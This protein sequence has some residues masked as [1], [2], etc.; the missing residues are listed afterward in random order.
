MSLNGVSQLVPMRRFLPRWKICAAAKIK[1]L[2]AKDYLPCEVGDLNMKGFS[3]GIEEEIPEANTQAQ[4]YFN[5][6]YFFDVEISVA[7]HKEVSGKQIYG[8]K[9]L[10]VRDA[11]R[12]KI[13][14]MMR[15]NFSG[16][17]GK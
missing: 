15:E 2:N 12:E 14:Q 8:I 4:L 10:K 5:E 13:Y 7:W 16:C 11:D 3:L 17:L 9:F 1:W 6:K